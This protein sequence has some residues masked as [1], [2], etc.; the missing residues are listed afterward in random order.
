[1]RHPFAILTVL[2]ALLLGLPAAGAS[3]AP[4]PP[5]IALPNGWAPEGIAA[6][7]TQLYVGSIP[8]GAIWTADALTG[9]GHVLVPAHEGRAAIGIE[10]DPRGRIFVAGGETGEAYVYDAR[11]GG[12]LAAFRLTDA[13]ETFINDVVV[14]PHAAYFTDSINQQLYVI[15]LGRGG[16]LPGPDAVRV[17]PLTGDLQY[18]DGFNLNGIVAARGGRTL[19][20]VQSNTGRVFA[21]DPAS[22]ATRAL[23]LGGALL[24]NG[25]GMLLRGRTLYVVQNRDNRIAQVQLAGDL[26]SGQLT[27]TLTDPDFDVPTTIARA[28][29]ALYAVNARFGTAPGPDVTYSIVRVG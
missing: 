16:A 21:I 10:V 13:A 29:G 4:P 12:D 17:L 26:G 6:H 25:D 24:T 23:D 8:T 27:G 7:G 3:A 1:M 11:T 14:T 2:V 28:A 18:T 19:L 9:A 20:S 5:T 22:G 15:P